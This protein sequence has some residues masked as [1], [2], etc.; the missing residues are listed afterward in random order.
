MTEGR[1]SSFNVRDIHEVAGL[2]VG[3]LLFSWLRAINVRDVHLVTDES[4]W[5]GWQEFCRLE[6]VRG[7][8]WIGVQTLG[9]KLDALRL[10]SL[11]V[12]D[13]HLVIGFVHAEVKLS[14]T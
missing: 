6:L 11:D 8:Q 1:D 12:V 10:S 2:D 7:I 4:H 5:L 13:L 3:M 14:R 9:L